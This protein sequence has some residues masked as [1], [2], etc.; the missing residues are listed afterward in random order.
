MVAKACEA[1]GYH[2]TSSEIRIEFS[3]MVSCIIREF[4]DMNVLRRN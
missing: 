3:Q 2:D 1:A 4:L